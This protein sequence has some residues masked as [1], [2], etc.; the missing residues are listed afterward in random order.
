[1]RDI[2]VIESPTAAAAALDPVRSQLLAE[3]AEPASA[4]TLAHRLDIPRQKLNYHLR[5]LEAHGLL[6]VAETRKWGGLTERLLVAT[7]SSYM[8]SPTALGAV[9]A[10]PERAADRL[11]ASYLIALAARIVR[12]VSSLLKKSEEVNKR[13]ATLAIE[14]EISFRSPSERAAFTEEMSAAVANLAAKYHDANATGARP[15]RL[16]VV[17]HPLLQSPPSTKEPS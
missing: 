7:A 9:A 2:Q 6:E 4:A 13:L 17:A 5:A 3:L 1:M 11:S 8:V 14:T 15:H 10:D 12:E 16:V